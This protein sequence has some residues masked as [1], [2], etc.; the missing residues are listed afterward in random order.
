MAAADIIEW[1][2]DEGLRVYGRIVPSRFNL[3]RHSQLVLKDPVGPVAAFT[4]WNF[5]INQ[6]VRK[7]AA[8][9]ATGCSM[10]VKAPEETPA[11]ARR[12]DSR[13]CRR[14]RAR[15]HRWAWSTAIRPRSPTTSSPP[16]HP[17]GHLHRFHPRGQAI[18][19]PGR[20]AH[21]ARDHGAGRPRP[22]HRGRRRRRGWPFAR[23]AVLPSS[24]TRAG[25]HLAHALSGA[26]EHHQRLC[27]RPGARTHRT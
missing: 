7:L 19:R 11:S 1:F 25:V 10:I 17:Q 6:V 3:A 13:L 4:P 9:L 12:A 15:R 5:P 23:P 27:R 14:G 20:Q 2:A 24:A 8:A 26:R 21:E 22:G 16:G 18:G